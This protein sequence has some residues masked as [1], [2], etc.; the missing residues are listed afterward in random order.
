MLFRS[1]PSSTTV[2]WDGKPAVIFGRKPATGEFVLTDGSGFDAKTYD[3]LATSPEMMA[4][5]QGTRG[6]DRAALI[7]IYRTL[8][9]Q[10]EA[11]TPANF[12]GYVK[13]DLLY[14][15]TP[16]LKSGNYV[17]RPNTVEYRIPARSTLGKRIGDRDRKSTRL[18]SSHT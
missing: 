2:K 15:S 14:M 4:Q 12:R 13:G 1:D 17:F 6:G 3:G 8:W 16:P 18:N 10:L 9:P 11:A 7:D 5:I